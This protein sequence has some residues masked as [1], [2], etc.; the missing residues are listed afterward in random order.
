MAATSVNRVNGYRI[1]TESILAHVH[2]TSGQHF[3]YEQLQQA[4]KKLAE[5]GP[6]VVDAATKVRPTI[7]MVE[8]ESDKEEKDLVITVKEKP[9]AK[10]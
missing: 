4:E 10:R 1:S 8:R 5:L 9:K 3:T 6:F 2:L 7:T